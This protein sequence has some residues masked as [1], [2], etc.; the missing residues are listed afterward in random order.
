MTVNP[1]ILEQR[2]TELAILRT[3]IDALTQLDDDARRRA[4]RWLNDLF[5]PPTKP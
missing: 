5:T 1:N 2:K 3:I 4:L